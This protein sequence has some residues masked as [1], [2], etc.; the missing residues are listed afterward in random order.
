MVLPYTGALD[1]HFQEL[2][3]CNGAVKPDPIIAGIGVYRHRVPRSAIVATIGSG[4]AYDALKKLIL[5]IILD[6]Q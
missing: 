2:A 5:D 4:T 1:R 6:L 3:D